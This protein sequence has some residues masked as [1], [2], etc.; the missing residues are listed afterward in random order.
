MDSVLQ[1]AQLRSL[2]KQGEALDYVAEK[3]PTSSDDERFLLMLQ[4][5]YAAEESAD[6]TRAQSYAR[7]LAE[8]EPNLISVQ[9]YVALSPEDFLG[10]DM[11]LARK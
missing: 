11:G 3:L 10:P 8:I 2:G 5:L 6:T 7:E 4:G 9:P 1:A